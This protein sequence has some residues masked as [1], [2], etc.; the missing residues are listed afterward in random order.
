MKSIQNFPG[1]MKNTI[2][3]KGKHLKAETP[4]SGDTEQ[5]LISGIPKK[6]RKF[7]RHTL[8]GIRSKKIAMPPSYWYSRIGQLILN[9]RTY[10]DTLQNNILDMEQEYFEAYDN[11]YKKKAWWIKYR[12]AIEFSM[13]LWSCA[14]DLIESSNKLAK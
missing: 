8:G 3:I 11:G 14:K 9:K 1:T 12:F 7:M 10:E 6:L 4:D 13:V 2:E 5:T